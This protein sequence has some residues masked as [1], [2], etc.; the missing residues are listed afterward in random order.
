VVPPLLSLPPP[1]LLR[2]A[3]LSPSRCRTF[4]GQRRCSARVLASGRLHPTRT[5]LC[6]PLQ[7]AAVET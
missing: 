4:L 6:V 2:V 1:L 7:G 3:T 5:R